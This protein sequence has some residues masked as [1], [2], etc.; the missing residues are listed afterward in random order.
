MNDREKQILDI[1]RCNPLIQQNEI[2]EML[3]ISRSR[4]ASHIMDL[5]RKGLIKG[6]GYILTEQDYCVVF[7]AIAMDI[8]GIADIHDPQSV[9]A[10]GRIHCSAGGVG[11][12]VAHNLA[13]LGRDVHLI[14]AVGDDLYG[15][16]LL[17]QT[18]LV[19]VNVQN[20][21][22]LRGQNTATSL[23]VTN[24][25]DEPV[26]AIND[27]PIFQQL[28]PQR[29]TRSRDLLSHAGVMMVDCNLAEDAL[30]WIVTI[31]GHIPLF[32]DTVS[33]CKA[34][35][36]RPWLAR[37]HTLKLSLD[38]L[39]IL[40][41]QMI[42]R[43][44]DKF[45]AVKSLHE[46]GVQRI[47]VCLDDDSVFCSRQDGEQHL[48]TSADHLT[49]DR[50]GADD[51]LMAGLIYRF[52][53]GGDFME[54]AHFAMACAAISRASASVNNPELSAESAFNLMGVEPALGV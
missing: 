2:G 28:T 1:L 16:T 15:E 34:D 17:E 33:G 24:S 3:H 48:L 40:S 5:M 9:A 14:S 50:V 43:E 4:V 52:M 13:L 44:A 11:R 38:T 23:S 20:C 47:F 53:Q 39:Q 26:L 37:I 45:A 49:R 36:I 54:C 41:G 35:K 46:Q 10:S 18:R 29:L 19:G 22:I 42:R 25:Q 30:E 27:N 31:A 12:N 21:L 6:K 8:R 51:A 32:V 7:G